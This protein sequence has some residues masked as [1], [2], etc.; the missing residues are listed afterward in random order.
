[1]CIMLC[2]YARQRKAEEICLRLGMKVNELLPWFYGIHF[3]GLGHS[4]INTCLGH[5]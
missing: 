4:L 3:H 1:M 2:S 5:P